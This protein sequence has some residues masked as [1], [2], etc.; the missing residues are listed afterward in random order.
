MKIQLTDD[1][2]NTILSE[3]ILQD[4]RLLRSDIWDL[5]KQVAYNPEYQDPNHHIHED[6][7]ENVKYL[8][9]LLTIQEYYG[10]TDTESEDWA[11][12]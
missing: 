6:L 2:V 7:N 4:I 1:M 3:K 10:L 9:A 8:N 11:T 5:Q 12:W